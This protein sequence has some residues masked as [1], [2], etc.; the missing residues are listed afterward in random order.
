AIVI[1]V[2]A[3]EVVAS[4][5]KASTQRGEGTSRWGWAMGKNSG[6]KGL[7]QGRQSD[8]AKERAARARNKKERYRNSYY[9]DAD[10]REFE[11]QV[12]QIGCKIKFIEGDGNCLFR[13]LADQLEGKPEEHA[14]YREKVMEHIKENQEIFEP[15]VEDDEPFDDYLFR[16]RRDAEW[17]GNQELVAAS[18]LFKANIVVHQFKAPRFFIPCGSANVTLH[19][20]YHGEHH[21]NSVRSNCDEGNGPALPIMLQTPTQGQGS[22]GTRSPWPEQE[23]E[24]AQ[25][26]PW[27]SPSSVTD[28]LKATEGR[29]EDAIELLIAARNET[30]LG[31]DTGADEATSGKSSASSAAPYAGQVGEANT[32]GGHEKG[33]GLAN[34][35]GVKS[36]QA[37]KARNKTAKKIQRGASCPCG[38]GL[39]Y[40]KCC[41][42]RDGAIARGQLPPQEP[43]SATTSP[44]NSRV[45]DDLGALVI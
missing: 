30:A 17:G 36:S 22:C 5:T 11:A 43:E 20:S 8:K 14:L 27:A 13:S 25:S 10:D 44:G 9:S 2:K 15:Y 29:G 16:M 33:E 39:K 35:N 38:S 3:F 42:K 45:A 19:L 1:L 12:G 34:G 40:M 6:K 24:V 41:K 4:I 21:Y 32:N 37:T 28:A 31:G 26:C 23:A 18:Q 7:G